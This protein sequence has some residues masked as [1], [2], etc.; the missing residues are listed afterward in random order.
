MPAGPATGRVE[1]K[2][3]ALTTSSTAPASFARWWRDP[4]RARDRVRSTEESGSCA[5]RLRRRPLAHFFPRSYART[6]ARGRRDSPARNGRRHRHGTRPTM[7]S[8]T[9]SGRSG[10]RCRARRRG[11]SRHR[12]CSDSG[13]GTLRRGGRQRRLVVA[14]T[15]TC[16]AS[17]VC[18]RFVIM[19]KPEERARP[20]KAS[21]LGGQPGAIFAWPPVWPRRHGPSRP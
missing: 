5:N 13:T 6:C 7:A 3:R 1:A 11:R 10:V 20:K 19:D 14:G 16:V 15:A 18:R 8:T 12:W 4:I 2:R 9:P 17:S 21:K